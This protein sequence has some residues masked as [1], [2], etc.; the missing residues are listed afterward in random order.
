M[1]KAGY[2]MSSTRRSDDEHHGRVA[3]FAEYNLTEDEE[4]ELAGVSPVYTQQEAGP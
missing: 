2:L 1:E 4:S 3:A